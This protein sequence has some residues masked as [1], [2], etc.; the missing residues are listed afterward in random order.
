[1]YKT[2]EWK[3]SNQNRELSNERDSDEYRLCGKTLQPTLEFTKYQAVGKIYFMRGGALMRR[4][5][6][7]LVAVPLAPYGT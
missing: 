4:S 3:N 5:H 1:M 7:P 2:A 6:L